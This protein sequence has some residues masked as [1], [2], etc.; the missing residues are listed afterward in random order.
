M[1]FKKIIPASVL[2]CSFFVVPFVYAEDGK[3]S[4]PGPSSEHSSFSHNR[5]EKWDKKVQ[6]IYN[7]LNLTAE[8]KKQLDDNKQKHREKMKA[9]FE[10]MRSYKE[11]LNQELMK[12]DLD[13][14][15]INAI[16]DQFKTLQSEITDGHLS[17]ILEV[18]KILTPQQFAKFIS[19]MEEHKHKESS[20][21]EK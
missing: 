3:K 17:S 5:H 21:E 20:A 16:Q 18:R 12:A 14:S 10:K 2:I 9:S 11:A 13:M 1:N 6:E 4:P 8:Q 7:Q 15:K 19:L